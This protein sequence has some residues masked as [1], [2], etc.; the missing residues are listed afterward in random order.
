MGRPRRRFAYEHPKGSGIYRTDFSSRDRT[1]NRKSVRL[2]SATPGAAQKEGLRLHD[3][4]GLPDDH[5]D[6][7]DPWRQSS[8]HE[9][10]RSFTDHVDA[11]LKQGGFSHWSKRTKRSHLAR[12]GRGVPSV[13]TLSEADVDRFVRAPLKGGDEPAPRTMRGRLNTA[14]AFLAWAR[15]EGL[16]RENVAE[17]VDLPRATYRRRNLRS[18]E[19]RG[20][21]TPAEFAR[22]LGVAREA[23]PAY[24]DVFEVCACTGLRLGEAV[25]RNVSHVSLGDGPGTLAVTSHDVGL[26]RPFGTKTGEDRV[27]PLVPRARAVLRRLTEGRGP[28][29]PLF[30]FDG[31]IRYSGDDRI[32]RGE[33][34]VGYNTVTKA[35]ARYRERAALSGTVTF[36][37]LRHSFVTWTLLV[38]VPPHAVREMAGHSSSSVQDTYAQMAK[39]M[40]GGD[41]LG[42][43]RDVLAYYAP[44]LDPSDLLGTR[45]LHLPGV[46]FAGA[47]GPY[48]AYAAL[49]A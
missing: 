20:P 47:L 11:Y 9:A 1:P 12:L 6:H 13:R 14:R 4:W 38:G 21:L 46:P 34:R 48:Q 39:S 24:A 37:S 2:R 7:F 29:E 3:R 5:P 8:P 31:P 33:R 28:D 41:P 35:F 30:L 43:A 49:F 32:P 45:A 40:A 42:A 16:V 26:R 23:E 17:R 27:V 19:R 15:S 44:D 36:H 18:A 22:L 10:A 25:S